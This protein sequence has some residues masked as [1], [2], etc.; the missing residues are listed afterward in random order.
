MNWILS[1]IIAT[2]GAT[3]YTSFL[4]LT[5]SYYDSKTVIGFL[6]LCSFIYYFIT[7]DEKNIIKMFE[8]YACIAG[9]LFGL[10][11]T[12]INEA[13][14]LSNNPGI[15]SC[16]VRS[17]VLITYILSLFVFGLKFAWSK[18]FAISV[19]IVGCLITILP[20]IKNFKSSNNMWILMTIIAGLFSSG[21]DILSK[22]SLNKIS[23]ENYLVI[24][25]LAAALT[26]IG[27]Q[28]ARTK[29]Y[30]LKVLP[31]DKREKV[32]KI[33]LFNKYPQLSLGVAFAGLIIFRKFLGIAIKKAT[34]PSYPRAIFNSQFLFSILLSLGIQKGSAINNYQWAGSSVILA[35]ILGLSLQK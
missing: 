30:S 6:I 18:F 5:Q 28:Y 15:P 17:N 2:F 22:L 13:I 33:Y 8:P 25:M 3:C 21:N 34:N 19:I 35:G 32:S 7:S 14:K 11:A 27:V 9:I 29:T 24:Q 20:D 26:A 1:S 16:I 4:K 12:S 23:T 31:K 10:M